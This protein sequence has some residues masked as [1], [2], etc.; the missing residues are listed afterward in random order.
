MKARRSHRWLLRAITT[1][2]FQRSRWSC[3]PSIERA[4]GILAPRN[5]IVHSITKWVVG[6]RKIVEQ[7][8]LSCEG[9]RQ[10]LQPLTNQSSTLSR[11]WIDGKLEAMGARSPEVL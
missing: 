6:Q 2:Q 11:D 8:A 1:G 7:K 9:K 10:R 4:G 5:G 3:G